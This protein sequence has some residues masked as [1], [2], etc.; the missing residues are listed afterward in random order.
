VH[1]IQSTSLS[2]TDLDRW[3]DEIL[4]SLDQAQ[5]DLARLLVIEKEIGLINAELHL[6]LKEI[7]GA[8]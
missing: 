5:K 6:R 7:E 3:A 8:L 2:H 4:F 1:A